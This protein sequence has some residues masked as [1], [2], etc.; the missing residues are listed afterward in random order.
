MRTDIE[1]ILTGFQFYLYFPRRHLYPSPRNS[2]SLARR[3]RRHQRSGSEALAKSSPHQNHMR[4]SCCSCFVGFGIVIMATHCSSSFYDY[5]SE[6]GVWLSQE[7]SGD[8]SDSFCLGISCAVHFCTLRNACHDRQPSILD[9]I[10][11]ATHK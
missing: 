9:R 2:S 5:R 1:I 4:C 8:S 6:H 7:R 10:K 11:R 3:T